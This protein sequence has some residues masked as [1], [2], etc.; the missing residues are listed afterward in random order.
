MLVNLPADAVPVAL[1]MY[2]TEARDTTATSLTLTSLGGGRWTANTTGLTSRW[3]PTVS[4]TVAGDPELVNLPYVDLPE[5]PD[6]V[7]SPEYVAKRAKIPLP[8]SEEDR[9][10]IID[11]IR[12]AQSDVVSHLGRQIMP[13]VFSETGRYDVGGQWNLVGLDDPLIEITSVT[14]ETADGQPT[15]AFTITYIAGINAKDDPAL[16]PI[17]RYV[18]A[19]AMNSPEFTLLWK[20][21]TKAKGDIKSVTTEGQSISYDKAT[22][23]GGGNA[24]SGA[25]GALPTLSSLDFWRL[26]G[27]RAFQRPTPDREPWPYTG[28]SRRGW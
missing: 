25:P 12:D 18:T 11:C 20:A 26:A 24:G 6:L 8:L 7:V 2:S 28:Y 16:H 23:G 5:V 13:T 15:G 17:R 27:R 9:E 22:L 3:Y 4:Y 14:A 10:Q 19:H 21:S 1:L